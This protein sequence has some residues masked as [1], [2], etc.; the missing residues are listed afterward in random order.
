M[1]VNTVIALFYYAAI[2][3]RMFVDAP[4]TTEEIRVPFKLGGAIAAT[5]V[6]VLILGIVPDQVGRLASNLNLF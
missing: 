5:A 6:A 4:T 2:A 3:K 1:A